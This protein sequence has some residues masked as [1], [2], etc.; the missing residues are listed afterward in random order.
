MD[1]T[2]TGQLNADLSELGMAQAE[3]VAKYFDGIKIDAVYS[4]DLIRAVHTAKPLADSKG[5]ETVTSP[6]LREINAGLWQGVAFTEIEKRFPDTYHVWRNDI[7]R[8]HCDGGESVAELADRVYSYI[9]KIAKEN[10][11]KSVAIFT[12]ATPLKSF[13]SLI[14]HGD[15]SKMSEIKW[16]K[17]ASVSK[18][19]FENDS[20]SAE[21][22]C[23]VSHLDGM[24]SELPSN[25]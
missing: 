1:K 24:V 16:T 12:H 18:F 25:V 19:L 21:F 14:T 20:F 23:D 15:V 7:G 11:G 3:R 17:N 4:S 10:T 13:I 9:L 22:I 2:F 6:S 8:S 5:L